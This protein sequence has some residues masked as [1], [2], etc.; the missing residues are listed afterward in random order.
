MP[1]ET[2]PAEVVEP[3]ETAGRPRGRRAYVLKMYPRFSETF[4]VSEILA[5]EAAGEELIIFS[6][7]P[8]TDTRFHPE[9]ARVRAQVI[10][11]ERPTSARSFW[12]TWTECAGQ[13]HLA[14]SLPNHLGELSEL[15]HDDAIQAL[16]IARL[17]LAHEVTHLHAHFASVATTV[18]RAASALTGIP[19]SF[20][21]HAKDIFHEDVVLADLARKTADAD[22][23]IAISEFNRRFLTS[24]LGPELSD[25]L[26]V[27]RNGL[28]LDRFPYRPRVGGEAQSGRDR[29]PAGCS[30]D[31]AVTIPS[32]LAVGR[33]VEKKGFTHLLTALARLRDAG[34]PAS[35]DLVGTGP[36]EG[37]L[38]ERIAELDLGRLVTLHGALTQAEVRDMFASHDLLVAPFV[39]GSDG[40]ADGLPTVLLEG[41]A[42]GIPCIAGT[43]TAVPEVIDHDRTGWLV[44]GDDPVDIADT[45]AEVVRRIR[46]TPAV[47]RAVTDAARELVSARHDSRTQ[48]E[49]LA[50]LA[51]A[52]ASVPSEAAESA[53]SATVA[54]ALPTIPELEHV[55]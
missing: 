51:D 22:H 15:A 30:G 2:A 41:M 52:A 38:R 8:S 23:V 34:T 13:P 46:D 21:T 14:A 26:V 39:I 16:Q 17:A 50:G 1:S 55:S 12:Q 27:V 43:V 31:P 18:A 45:I 7:R 3:T 28:E 9:L 49:K 4:I 24:V 19:Y 42:T 47:V 25:R 44:T 35:L 54:P 29:G 20:T 32:L 48:A 5:R 36:L 6:L 11:V 33:L 53:S 10:H 40:N 37:Q